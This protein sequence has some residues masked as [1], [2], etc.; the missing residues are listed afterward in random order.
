MNTVQGAWV[1]NLTWREVET[2]IST[3]ATG[4]LPVGAACKEHG[5][6]LPMN[7]DQIQAE[8]FAWQLAHTEN[9]LIWPTVTYGFYPAFTDYPGSCTLHHET[10]MQFVREIL[11]T[12][13]YS[14]VSYV[15]I[16]NTGISTIKPLEQAINFPVCKNRVTLFNAYSG[17]RFLQV[18]NDIEQQKHG[19]HADE[20]ETSIM[21]AIAPEHV[22]MKSIDS[23][24]AGIARGV[25]NRRDPDSP[26]YS[27]SGVVGAPALAT[28]EKGRQLCN[29]VLFDLLDL[30]RKH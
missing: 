1:A 28:V 30:Y 6:H 24:K 21:L 18:Q 29:A 4:I 25:L 14:G 9:I 12:I 10:F 8:W 20:I 17:K 3:G 27:A 19:G 22:D 5:F 13:I 2:R 23:C 16:I 11:E 15:V 26:G 7:T